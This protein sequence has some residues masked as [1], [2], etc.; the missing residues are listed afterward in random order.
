MAALAS[1][2]DIVNRLTGGSSGTPEHVFFWVD[3]R[4]GSGAA[5]STVAGRWTSLWQYNKH[6]GG[7]GAVPTSAAVPVNDTNGALFQTDPGGGREKWLLGMASTATQPGQLLLYDRLLHNGGLSGS[8]TTAQTV[9]GTLTRNTGG[10][11]NQIWLEINAFLGTTGTT[12]TASYTNQSGTSGR[13]TKAAVIGGTGWRESERMFP[14]ALQDG[15]TGVQAVASVTLAATTAATGNFGVV[16]VRPL[17]LVNISGTA[18]GGQRDCVAGLPQI[19]RVDTDAC[20]SLAWY[21]Q[22]TTP[23]ALYGSL[24]MVEA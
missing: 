24:S 10:A 5:N 19:P 16:V 9:G 6:P 4:I 2:S 21:A 13:T 14:L 11:G 8:V 15:D 22:S 7:Q 3:S 17:L 12:V 20:L 23:P 1:L 18:S